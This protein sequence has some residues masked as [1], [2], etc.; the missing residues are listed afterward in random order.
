MSDHARS[1]LRTR[2]E[3]AMIEIKSYEPDQSTRL[4]PA[5]FVELGAASPMLTG[6]TATAGWHFPERKALLEWCAGGF[7]LGGL[8]LLGLA[9]P[10]L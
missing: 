4:G 2:E 5:I 10:M 6:A 9:F 7:V 1:R 8:A 3:L